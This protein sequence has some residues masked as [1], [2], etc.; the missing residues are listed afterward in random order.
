[1]IDDIMRTHSNVLTLCVPWSVHVRLLPSV[2]N[3]HKQ[4]KLLWE[5]QKSP[6]RQSVKQA[7]KPSL[8]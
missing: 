2:T 3:E 7:M 8:M 4:Y 1:M 6:Y 5:G